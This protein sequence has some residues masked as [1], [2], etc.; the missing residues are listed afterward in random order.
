[1]SMIHLCLSLLAIF[2]HQ[3]ISADVNAI[4]G[5]YDIE[6]KYKVFE[7]RVPFT[8]K[9]NVT[10]PPPGDDYQIVWYKGN[11]YKG[12]KSITEATELSGRLT[13]SKD[14]IT[15]RKTT[16]DDAGQYSCR[17]IDPKSTNTTPLAQAD[18]DVIMKPTAK[19]VETLTVIEGEKLRLECLVVGSPPPTVEWRIGNDT[20]FRSQG[21]IKLSE[22]PEKGTANSV[23]QIDEATM[24]DRGNYYCHGNNVATRN[25]QPNE[26][27][28]YVRVKDKLAALWPFLGICIEVIVLCTVIFIYEKKRNKT[29]LEESDTDQSPEQDKK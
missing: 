11:K 17:L 18:F 2:V 27:F 15:I 10:S 29:E 22:H 4:T 23:L 28:V 9:C 3:S 21:R 24:A 13:Q 8:L 14:S 7:Y 20:Y 12:N 26:A 1:M 25:S 6:P 19:L 5:N 16:V